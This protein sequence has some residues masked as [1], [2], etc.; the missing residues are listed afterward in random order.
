MHKALEDAAENFGGLL[1]IDSKVAVPGYK[2]EKND[3]HIKD[4]MTV[5]K[6]VGIKSYLRQAGGGSDANIFVARGVKAIDV[7]TGVQK[8]HTVE[9][10]ISIPDMIKMT[11]FLFEMVKQK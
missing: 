8:P 3:P 1:S 4:I 9:E 11:E 6:R 10:R 7:G 2:F 5:M